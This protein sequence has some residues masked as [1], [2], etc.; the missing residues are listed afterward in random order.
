MRGS[1]KHDDRF[2][3][4]SG[5]CSHPLGYAEAFANAAAE[6][7]DLITLQGDVLCGGPF[8]KW[9]YDFPA[10]AKRIDAVLAAAGIESRDLTLI[11]YSQG[12][13][14]AERLAARYPQKFTR[15]ILMSSP[16]VPSPDRLRSIDAAV[17]M[18]GT[19]ESQSN[20]RAG[21]QLLVQ[22]HIPVTFL[23]IP[24]ARHG[25]FGATPDATM[26][27]AL[28]WLDENAPAPVTPGDLVR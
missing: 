6:H 13:E 14:I 8:R 21:R 28:A 12:A 23:P 22:A 7:G 17:F 2:I 4:L 26:A 27:G 25:Q 15:V 11:G 19:L 20:M 1:K 3:F 18:A 24:G 10:I 9:S 5:M 16:I